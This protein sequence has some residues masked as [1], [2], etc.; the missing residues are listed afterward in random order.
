MWRVLYDMC[1]VLAGG[2]IVVA[3]RSPSSIAQSIL[4]GPRPG[5]RLPEPQPRRLEAAWRGVDALV[6]L[7]CCFEWLIYKYM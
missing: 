4:G 1:P 6:L 7:N 5:L 3:G 2:G